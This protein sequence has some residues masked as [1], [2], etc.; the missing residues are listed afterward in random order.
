[1]SYSIWR[2]VVVGVL[3]VALFNLTAVGIGVPAAV[4]GPAKQPEREGEVQAQAVL[5]VPVAAIIALGACLAVSLGW[6]ILEFSLADKPI[7]DT[8]FSDAFLFEIGLLVVVPCIASLVIFGIPTTTLKLL[9]GFIRDAVIAAIIAFRDELAE[10]L[11]QG[12]SGIFNFAKSF[13]NQLTPEITS[14]FRE[15]VGII[16]PVDVYFFVDLSGSFWDDLPVFKAQAPD[17]VSLTGLKMRFPNIRFGLG[18]FED[19][20]IDPFGVAVC[21]DKAY[22]IIELRIKS[23]LERGKGGDNSA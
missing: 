3:I 5:A 17:I 6:T 12:I 9:E 18:K 15:E 20:P 21:G 2:I 23:N 10:A 22:E 8:P 11:T 7:F 19:Y 1:V 14:I 4:L 13:V 16:Q